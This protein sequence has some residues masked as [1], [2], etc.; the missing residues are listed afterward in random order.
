VGLNAVCFLS[1]TTSQVSTPN[2]TKAATRGNNLRIVL[3]TG[4][5]GKFVWLLKTGI[6]VSSG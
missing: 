5:S 1:V 6:T 2:I 4:E 3:F